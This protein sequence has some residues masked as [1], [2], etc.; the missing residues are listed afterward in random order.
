MR[1]SDSLLFFS[2]NYGGDIPFLKVFPHRGHLAQALYDFSE[3]GDNIFDLFKGIILAQAENDIS[4]SQ[5][6]MQANSG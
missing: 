1:K 4:L 2:G 6:D 5:S 3:R